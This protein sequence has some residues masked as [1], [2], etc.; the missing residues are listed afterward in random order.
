MEALID[1]ADY[2]YY[3]RLEGFDKSQILEKRMAE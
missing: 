2:Y 1:V 3:L